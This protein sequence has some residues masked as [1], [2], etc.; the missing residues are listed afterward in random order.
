MGDSSRGRKNGA[1]CVAVLLRGIVAAL[2][3]AT[4]QLTGSKETEILGIAHRG[5]PDIKQL[6]LLQD[7]GWI[8]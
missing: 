8:W 6:L 7:E 4:G 5:V 2:Q 3:Q 1:C